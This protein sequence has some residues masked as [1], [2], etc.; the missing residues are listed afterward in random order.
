MAL[1]PTQ[2][3]FGSALTSLNMNATPQESW[4]PNANMA[5]VD[6]SQVD[7]NLQ[8]QDLHD[9]PEFA[10][11]L[12]KNIIANVRECGAWYIGEDGYPIQ[13]YN[14]KEFKF[15]TYDFPVS[16]IAENPDNGAIA[17][18]TRTVE[19]H[20][21]DV[22]RFAIGA[23]FSLPE[24]ANQDAGD[25]GINILAMVTRQLRACA[26][27]T[28][29]A[30]VMRTMAYTV[31]FFREHGIKE[32]FFGQWSI[33]S[34]IDHLKITHGAASRGEGGFQIMLELIA[35]A[36]Q[37]MHMMTLNRLVL[38]RTVRA[39]IVN[40]YREAYTGGEQGHAKFQAGN[41]AM[42][43]FNGYKINVADTFR[44]VESVQAEN[45]LERS[46]FTGE[47]Y[48]AIPKDGDTGPYESNW[49][50][51]KLYDEGR[52][53]KYLIPY[54][55]MVQK[56]CWWDKNGN[57]DAKTV[58]KLVA[59][60][61]NE[62]TRMARKVPPGFRTTD[63]DHSAKNGDDADVT[64]PPH[65]AIIIDRTNG[66]LTA[67]SLLLDANGKPM[68]SFKISDVSKYWIERNNTT[69][70]IPIGE[71]NPM[72]L[73]DHEEQK[74]VGAAIITKLKAAKQ[75]SGAGRFVR[76][77]SEA[78]TRAVSNAADDFA[79][80]GTRNIEFNSSELKMY[81]A[82]IAL[83][84]AGVSPSTFFTK[85]S[86]NGVYVA[87]VRTTEEA[88]Q[89]AEAHGFVNVATGVDPALVKR[90]SADSSAVDIHD[91]ATIQSGKSTAGKAPK[92]PRAVVGVQ[93]DAAHMAELATAPLA[94]HIATNMK[95]VGVTPEKGFSHTTVAG[96]TAFSRDELLKLPSQN[97]PFHFM[98]IRDNIHR[99]MSSVIAYGDQ[100]GNV[101][102]SDNK[103]LSSGNTGD[104]KAYMSF[105]FHAG[106]FTHTP[107]KIHILENVG[108][109]AYNGGKNCEIVDFTGGEDGEEEIALE[110]WR[111]DVTAARG[112]IIVHAIPVGYANRLQIASLTG[113]FD[114]K[115]Y[116]T[117]R[118]MPHNDGYFPGQQFVFHRLEL[119]EVQRNRTPELDYMTAAQANT[120]LI[121]GSCWHADESVLSTGSNTLDGRDYDGVKAVRQGR[122]FDHS[123]LHSMR[124]QGK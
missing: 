46:V 69:Y 110:T 72:Q 55:D 104:M 38:H 1:N 102:L 121:L 98:L 35:D 15:Q 106:A 48:M 44:K 76:V 17:H 95:F 9:T 66:K 22:E 65:P 24:L 49:K 101:M 27:E 39:A 52:D 85:T 91:V 60:Y 117:E 105:E 70:R 113:E 40:D 42:T 111:H 63:K 32:N 112:D 4:K 83:A 29:A 36:R 26:L 21:G 23:R 123:H 61:N 122:E 11:K 73:A 78:A 25:Q 58:D 82:S 80:V 51:V 57:V 10:D 56:L 108:Y 84:A 71:M 115:G 88:H 16:T 13:Q 30:M 18:V 77:D 43:T 2:T 53:G 5:R 124:K 93:L 19:A 47:M 99:T 50:G 7:T 119:D 89:L 34:Y 81:G 103:S 68:T 87:A 114:T 62:Q 33:Q 79:A 109:I 94:T 120:L 116:P 20:K 6:L 37:K 12:T 8:A 97:F 107:E 14:R 100:P 90:L 28:L 92:E 3:A 31:N 75:S 74:K 118:K 67:R 96:V 45:V 41:V 86:D 54:K 59:D 64:F